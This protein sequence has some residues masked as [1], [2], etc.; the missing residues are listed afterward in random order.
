MAPTSYFIMLII[1]CL[2]NS[3]V[4]ETQ[5]IQDLT[6]PSITNNPE[7][8][9]SRISIYKDAYSATKDT[10]AIVLCTEWDE[11]IVSNKR[12]EKMSFDDYNDF[13]IDT[14]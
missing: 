4:E 10:H 2:S 3:Q 6:H 14:I 11:F 8:I 13:I 1:W 7:D 5:I 9:K 12:E